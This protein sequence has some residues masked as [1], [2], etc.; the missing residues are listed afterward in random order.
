[1]GATL[2]AFFVVRTCTPAVGTRTTLVV[3]ASDVFTLSTSLVLVLLCQSR[4]HITVPKH[5]IL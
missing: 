3:N 1:M 2:V 4:G 5:S